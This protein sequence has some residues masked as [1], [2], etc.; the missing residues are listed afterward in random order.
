MEYFEL[1]QSEKV[2]N[3]IVLLGL[4]QEDYTYAMRRE[5]FDKLDKL[6][7]AYFSGREFEEICDILTTPTFLISER[8]RK[9]FV[10]YEKDLECKSVQ[11][12]PT[13]M[14]SAQ[15]P[16]YCVPFF[17]LIDACHKNTVVNELGMVEKLVLDKKKIKDRQIFRLQGLLEYKVIVSVAAAESILRRRFYGIGLREIEV[18]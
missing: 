2:E 11:V 3:P 14:E 10:L 5:D 18:L 15:Y 4:A 16:Q 7:V 9:L 6:K 13:A 8:M 12:F 17:P 1:F